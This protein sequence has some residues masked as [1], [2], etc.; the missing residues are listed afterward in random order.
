M[1]AD[2]DYWCSYTAGGHFRADGQGAEQ[3]L[4]QSHDRQYRMPYHEWGIFFA[5]SY[6]EACGGQYGVKDGVSGQ[7]FVLLLLYQVYSFIYAD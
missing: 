2:F 5:A 1:D 3:I 4:D 7:F 6:R